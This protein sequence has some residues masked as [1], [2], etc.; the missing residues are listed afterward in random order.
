M[1][2][3]IHI[4]MT[5]Y[6]GWAYAFMEA[7]TTQDQS[8]ASWG[9]RRADGPSSR[10]KAGKSGCPCSKAAGQEE[11]PTPGGKVSLFVLFR[12]SADWA[13]LTTLGRAVCFTQ[14]TDSSVHLIQRPLPRHTQNH[15][16]PNIWASAAQWRQ[17]IKVTITGLLCLMFLL[18]SLA[19]S[20]GWYY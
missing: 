18:I 12:P 6:E 19:L 14:S 9:P 16:Q 2:T 1:Y 4:Y 10:L 20:S 17:H 7:D 13:R 11:F 15:V 8:S 3:Y 5:Y